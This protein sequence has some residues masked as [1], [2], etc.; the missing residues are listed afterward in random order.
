MNKLKFIFLTLVGLW[1]F[2]GSTTAQ[3]TAGTLDTTFGTGGK[4]TVDFNGNPDPNGVDSDYGLD[5]AIQ[6]DGKIVMVG[7]SFVAQTDSAFSMLRLNADGSLDTS[8]G[9]GGRVINNI[10]VGQTDE[11]TSVAIQPDGKIVVAGHSVT[12]TNRIV[13]RYNSNGTLDTGFGTSGVFSAPIGFV[14][15]DEADLAL[16]SD[17]KVVVVGTTNVEDVIS[18]SVMRL[19][20]DGILDNSFGA[21]GKVN[22]SFAANDRAY[23][24][25]LQSDGKI[26]VAGRSNSKDMA[27]A[28]YNTN[29]SLDT[30]FDGDGKATTIFPDNA[31]SLIHSLAIQPD[32]KIIAAGLRRA[33]Q[34][35]GALV[36]YSADGSLDTSFG[37]NGIAIFTLGTTNELFFDVHVRDGKIIA[38]GGRQLGE[39][40]VASDDFVIA[41]F[42]SNGTLDTS[43]G[44]NGSVIT[45][46][47]NSSDIALNSVFQA[48]GKLVQIGYT[49]N[50]APAGRDFAVVR[51]N[52]GGIRDALV[53]FNGD[54]KTDW[55]V[56]RLTS[57]GTPYVWWI[58]YN[59]TENGVGGFQFGLRGLDTPVPLD[60]DGDGKDDVAV[61]R[62]S[63]TG[64]SYY[65][66]LNSS[67]N[68]VSAVYTGGVRGDSA[69]PADY[70]GDGKDDPAV[71]ISPTVAQGAG[72]SYWCYVGSLNNPQQARTCVQWGSRYNTG[73]NDKDE[74]YPGDFDGDG[75]ADFAVQRPIN[76]SVPNPPA[77]SPAIFY[78]RT[79]SGNTFYEYFGYSGDR[80]L[81]GDYDGDG[82]TDL[83]V[84]RGFNVNPGSVNWYIRYRNGR[85]DSYLTFGEGVVDSFAQGDYNGD[86][87]D[88][89]AVFRR[90]NGTFYWRSALNANIGGAYQWGNSSDLPAAGYNNR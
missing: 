51:Y 5:V 13:V 84:S 52:F 64:T 45:D 80:I 28:R 90:D 70:D 3:N 66:I 74:P 53:D 69:V 30:G 20:S 4:V 75:K 47:N 22:T 42:D 31:S 62:G 26:V 17:G 49:L 59:G 60:Y 73:L 37:T 18:F 76:E 10:A 9:T 54:G 34:T 68:T 25:Q 29:G 44:T 7:F 32:G 19:N 6:P 1:A 24:V 14:T 8:F 11:A 36:R 82:K 50:A 63:G 79:A 12:R 23:S 2:A 46:F 67:T 21:G 57:P 48:D 83:A 43:F 16:Q 15:F 27:I 85:P 77:N 72:F 56:I 61:W 89:I 71:F 39:G 38:T 86:G 58:R 35:D 65:F 78:I 55:A 33:G 41:R 81:P 40:N 88:D 87:A